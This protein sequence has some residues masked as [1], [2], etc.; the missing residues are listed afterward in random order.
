MEW[1]IMERYTGKLDRYNKSFFVKT[2]QAFKM[3]F[4]VN[5]D[6]YTEID[7]KGIAEQWERVVNQIFKSD[8]DWKSYIERDN[9]RRGLLKYYF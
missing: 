1:W 9:F 8:N 2:K 3:Y 7:S 5:L 6:D 4:G